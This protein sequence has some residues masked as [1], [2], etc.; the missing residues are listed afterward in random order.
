MTKRQRYL[1]RVLS[2][3]IDV[4]AAEACRIAPTLECWDTL[5]AKADYHV[6]IP[7][8]ETENGARM[9]PADHPIALS[10]YWDRHARQEEAH[11][12]AVH[13]LRWLAY[14]WLPA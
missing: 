6:L 10:Q 7:A 3:A 12:A 2:Q 11:A 5:A 14:A 8:P 4:A 1:R 13:D 9:V